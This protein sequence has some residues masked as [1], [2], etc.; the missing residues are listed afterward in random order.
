LN[1]VVY[2]ANEGEFRK[3]GT[4]SSGE[5]NRFFNKSSGWKNKDGAVEMA[6]SPTKAPHRVVEIPACAADRLLSQSAAFRAYEGFRPLEQAQLKEIEGRAAQAIEGKGRC[7]WNPGE[8]GK[9]F[10]FGIRI[11]D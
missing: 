2:A 8:S 11:V 4:T 3:P 5:T 7:W 9:R 10:N 6:G 1:R